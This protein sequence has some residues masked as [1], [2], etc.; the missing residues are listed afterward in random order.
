MLCTQNEIV[1]ALIAKNYIKILEIDKENNVSYKNETHNIISM[2][3]RFRRHKYIFRESILE[4][5]FGKPKCK[6]YF[7]LESSLLFPDTR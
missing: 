5:N 2:V 3:K 6:L 4:V 1:H 7:F